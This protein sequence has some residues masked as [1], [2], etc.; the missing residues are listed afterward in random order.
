[1][2]ETDEGAN[3]PIPDD[4]KAKIDA[5][6][7]EYEREFDRRQD[8]GIETAAET[9]RKILEQGIGHSVVSPEEVKEQPEIP[10]SVRQGSP[11]KKGSTKPKSRKSYGPRDTGPP[12][13]INDD[14]R[15]AQGFID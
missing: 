1:M 6:R 13:H 3:F 2:N 12:P 5:D 4:A 15:R 11:S 14:V 8:M 10:S 7:E 9:R